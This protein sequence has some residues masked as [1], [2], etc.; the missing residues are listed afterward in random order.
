MGGTVRKMV[1]VFSPSTIN[2]RR[3]E[4]KTYISEQRQKLNDIK[5]QIDGSQRDKNLLYE[6]LAM[7]TD[8]NGEPIPGNDLIHQSL[9]AS[10]SHLT[11]HSN[12]LIASQGQL[13][14]LVHTYNAYELLKPGDEK[15]EKVKKRLLTKIKAEVASGSSA[16]N[17]E[18]AMEEENKAMTDIHES[19]ADLTTSISDSIAETYAS[20][21]NMLPPSGVADEIKRW[22]DS[23][24][25]QQGNKQQYQRAA[26]ARVS[27][28]PSS[29]SEQKQR[30]NGDGND[31][32][33]EDDVD[34]RLL[35]LRSFHASGG[36][37]EFKGGA[38]GS[39]QQ[40]QQPPVLVN[41]IASF[42]SSGVGPPAANTRSKNGEGSTRLRP[43]PLVMD[44]MH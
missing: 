17:K 44:Q 5:K 6:Q 24:R 34:T 38:P 23:R 4:E 29:A 7:V 1:E 16:D 35:A 25:L 12:S 8:D 13:E 42:N 21:S 41:T 10:L 26:V 30:P 28:L 40:Q 36:V 27:L 33:N 32:Y 2:R 15:D 37:V 20:T 3:E 22:K 19:L 18:Q 31:D 39:H 14:R 9:C 43:S 11:I